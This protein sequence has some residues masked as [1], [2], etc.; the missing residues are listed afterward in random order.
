MQPILEKPML[1]SE[2]MKLRRER[3]AKQQEAIIPFLLNWTTD[4]EPQI[5]MEHCF[6]NS[7]S[8]LKIENWYKLVLIPF[9]ISSELAEMTAK[10]VV[11]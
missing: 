4:Y 3:S 9:L 5:V 8:N 11:N 1:F 6:R 2:R 10:L 7:N